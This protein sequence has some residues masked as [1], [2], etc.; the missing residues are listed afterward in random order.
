MFDHIFSTYN[1]INYTNIWFSKVRII[2]IMTTQVLFSMFFLKKIC[3][4][5]SLS[6]KITNA[7]TSLDDDAYWMKE[8][9][10]TKYGKNNTLIL[11]ATPQ[12]I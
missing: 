6:R 8:I 12:E 9:D 4:L 10:I 11:I 7:A 2:L 3:T 1:Q 5:M